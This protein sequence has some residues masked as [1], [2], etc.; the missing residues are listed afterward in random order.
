M[1]NRWADAA[2][3][4]DGDADASADGDVNADVD[5]DANTNP[6]S[7]SDAG[8]ADG[9]SISWPER[10]SVLEPVHIAVDVAQPYGVRI[11]INVSATVL[12]PEAE[13]YGTFDLRLHEDSRYVADVP[14]RLPFE[15]LPGYWWLVVHIETGLPVAGERAL[16]FE[17]APIDF[18]VLS[19]TLPSGVMLSVPQAFDEVTALG[20]QWAGGRV[21]RYEDGEVALWWAPGPTEDLLL[22]NAIVMLETTHD[23]DDPPAV[24]NVEEGEWQGRTAFFFREMWPGREGGASE[25]WVIQD[26]D[27]WLYVLRVRTVGGDAIPSLMHDVSGTFAFVE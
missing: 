22:N 3:G 10:V 1:H 27:F 5:T 12:D 7:D 16:G 8:T 11:P 25:A 19:E 24:L 26:E 17:P 9:G 23:V 18:R 15:P 2:T 13:T 14:L 21:W 4:A 6:D 20:D